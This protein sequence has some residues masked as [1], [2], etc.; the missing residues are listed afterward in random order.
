MFQAIQSA[1][2]MA[3]NQ[4]HYPSFQL[5]P[6]INKNVSTTG[7]VLSYSHMPPVSQSGHVPQFRVMVVNQDHPGFTYDNRSKFQ[8]ITQSGK[9]ISQQQ[10]AEISAS[11]ETDTQHYNSGSQL[12]EN[13]TSFIRCHFLYFGL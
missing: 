4:S 8:G 11:G 1:A 12:E 2:G 9:V 10:Y 7:T 3:D 13:G 5:V 6:V